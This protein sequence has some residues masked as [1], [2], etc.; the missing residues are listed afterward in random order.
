MKLEQILETYDEKY[1]SE[2]E[3]EFIFSEWN[4]ESI[5]FQINE[6]QKFLT[7]ESKWLDIACGTGFIL[8][9]YDVENKSGL[10]ISLPMLDIAK[11]RNPST[12]FYNENFLSKNN[13]FNNKW[14]VITCMWWAYCMVESISQIKQ[15][16]ENI[17]EWLT[18]DGV[19]FIPLCNPQKFDSNN[20]KIPYQ[21]KNVP[22]DIR[23]TGITW[24]WEQVNGKRHD[25]VISPQV[26][27]MKLIFEEYFEDVKIVNGDI[28]KIG[29][30]WRVQDILIAKSK[31]K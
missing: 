20:I 6:L 24:T 21:D 17:S 10:D 2:Y 7:K 19:C 23:I 1:A 3:D 22:G 9:Q 18:E 31:R 30:G 14:N 25:D 13:N 8:S 29:E 28:S 27:H 11:L 12:T 16:A 4:T 5:K 26:E 15:L